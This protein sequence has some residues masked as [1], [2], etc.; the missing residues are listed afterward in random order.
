MGN[1]LLVY[2]SSAGSGK[3]YS[4]VKTYLSLL[5]KIKSDY[6]FKQVLAITFTNKAAD[7][8]KKR[9]LDALD[10]IYLEGPQN[11][12]ALEIS[13]EN[14]FD[15]NQ[16]VK[17][18][19]T[20]TIKILHNYKDFNLMTI[21]KFTNRVIRSFSN[22]LGIS[23]NYNIVLEE[24][25]FLEEVISKYIDEF[26]KDKEQ[27][28]ILE[29]MIDQSIQLDVN[30]DI[31][32]QLNKLKKIIFKSSR[33]F[34]NSMSKEDISKLKI[35]LF[36]KLIDSKNKLK[37]IGESGI[38]ILKDSNVLDS[39]LSY[40]R[41]NIILNTFNNLAT[42]NYKDI[43]KWNSWLLKAQWFK[44]SLSKEEISIIESIS[45]SIITKMT[46][47][48]N[49]LSYRLKLL[50]VHKLIVPFSM[51]Q[52][53]MDSIS[54]EK[55]N[56]NSILISDFNNLVSEI[57]KN[58]PAGFIFEKIGSKYQYILI[59]EFQDTSTLQWNNLIPLVHESL[60]VGGEN[61]IVGDA[62]QA[63]YRWRNGNVNQFIE[64][65]KISDLSLKQS[66]E[67]LFTT[68]FIEKK[69]ENNWRSSINIIDF[70]NW[71]F[72]D[73][74]DNLNSDNLKKA[75]QNLSQ[76]CKR[77]FHGLVNIQVSEKSEF[78]LNS[79][80]KINISNALNNGYKLEDISILVRSKKDGLKVVNSMLE[81]D[82]PFISDDSLFLSSSI[83]FKVLNSALN[84]FEFNESRDHIILV[85]FLENYFSFDI[86]NFEA[87]KKSL[88][89]FDFKYYANLSDFEKLSFTL[90]LL[91]INPND[92]FVD[93][94][95]NLSHQLLLK[96]NFSMLML[97]NYYEQKSNSLTVENAPKNALQILTVHKSKGLEFP[98]V[99]VPFTNWD[100]KNNN[101]T[102][103]TFIS[104]VDLIDYNIDLYIGEMSN[105]SLT[106]LD[107]KFIYEIEEGEVLLDKMNLYYVAFTRAIDQLYISFEE[108]NN[109]N[110]ISNL[111]ISS[112]KNHSDYNFETKSLIFSKNN[113][114][115]TIKRLKEQ[116]ISKKLDLPI[117]FSNS[118]FNSFNDNLKFKPSIN[119]GTFFH[120]VI[121]KIY[122]DFSTG[123]KYLDSQTF[124]T[125]FDSSFILK[126][127]DLLQ[128]IENNKSLSFIYQSN[129]LIY[130]EREFLSSDGDIYRL[131][132]LLIQNN[133][134]IIIDY[135]T[136]K[137]D[138]DINQLTNYLTNINL[139]EFDNVSAFLLYVSN[140]ELLEVTLK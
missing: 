27:L 79:F 57:I 7:E 95:M 134:A 126:C 19:K 124:N 55:Q 83:A 13:K 2:R 59:D 41:V 69:L 77:N 17:R 88:K 50:E 84:F 76:Y 122:T 130:N 99:I 62:K 110:N 140:N 36:K 128:K 61:L 33:R 100:T 136:S 70:N 40:G 101:D 34:K 98:V 119:F 74:I 10:S 72:K 65:P 6:G 56:Q 24:E 28:K 106:H 51:I 39:W 117:S 113:E 121:S 118:Y 3:T 80:L 46:S 25:E 20:I 14:N 116:S 131:D 49:E 129:Q 123:Y 63:I 85:H 94:F 109:E 48:I 111:M 35:F 75:Y 18:A 45:D 127:K 90:N 12:L 133:K 32:R 11:K 108:S 107:K 31:E 52:S 89:D 78:E 132:R 29:L 139:C 115:P 4:L 5:F 67:S 104:N 43:E 91:K 97:L 60:S 71:I 135:K 82:I 21:D 73:I 58:E 105:K 54:K 26:S 92:P 38:K 42:L 102:P 30:N 47:I 1:Q 37:E 103:Y 64:L 44:K 120:D 112:I 68:S 23:N 87:A 81:L 53:L 114:K 125:S 15:I 16:V 9:V 96:D 66:Y 137:G 93:F 8:M 86:L 138:N 22:E